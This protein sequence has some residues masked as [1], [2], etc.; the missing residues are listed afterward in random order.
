MDRW[1]VGKPDEALAK[2]IEKQCDLSPLCIKVLLSR[3][4]KDLSDIATFF[5][6]VP[7]EDPFMLKD[8]QQAVDTI[9][10]AIDSFV[11]ICVYGDYDCDGVTATAVLYNYL[12]CSGAN[13]IYYI[14]ERSEGYGMN[15]DAVRRLAE[16][17][18]KLIVTVDN[19]ISAVEEAELIEELGM[20]LVVTDHHKPPEVLPKAVAIVDPHRLDCPS[21]FKDIAGVGVALK[22][23]AALDG[24]D[25]DA[26]LEQYG[27]LVAIGTVADVV[28]LKGENRTIVNAGMRLL[29]N[30]ENQGLIELM[31]LSGMGGEKAQNMTC[32]DIAF[33]LAPRIN[34]AGRFGSP[35]SAVAL[36]LSEDEE[37]QLKAEELNDLNSSRKDCEKEIIAQIKAK[38]EKNRDLLSEKVLVIDGKGWHHGVV[39]IVASKIMEAYGKPCVLI[40]IDNNGMARGSARSMHGFNIFKCLTYCDSLLEKS[41]GHECA[42]GLSIK[43]ENIP[44][45]KQMVREYADKAETMPYTELKADKLLTREDLT[46][47]QVQSLEKLEPFGESNPEPLFAMVSAKV[48]KVIPLSQG[49]HTKLEVSYD[50]TVQDV[51]LFGRAPER[52]GIR[53]GDRVDIMVRAGIN[54]YGGTRSVSLKAEDIRLSGIKQ[55][56]AFAAMRCYDDIVCRKNVE[57]KLAALI[58]PERKELLAV[59]KAIGSG[60]SIDMLMQ[61]MYL[62]CNMNFGKT[63]ACADI[64]CE[65]GIAKL[66]DG[67]RYIETVKTEGKANL[68][69]TKTMQRFSALQTA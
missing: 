51:L 10:K 54:E 30:T 67:C 27:D 40:S 37:A 36:L 43:E 47:G 3:G 58:K 62:E 59:Y 5:E 11:P 26:V 45:F 56:K 53:Q 57:P 1:T 64:F 16:S 50:S 38:I 35:K 32:S 69:A 19:G 34:A 52:L 18:I 33:R 21:S 66:S 6:D 14:P 42:G 49:K 4:C 61:R 46:C 29:K 23:C 65:A 8:M 48:Q 12:E 39:G 28:P 15:V 60:I 31:E 24:G 9:N 68:A 13:V 2:E 17:G 55:Q 20:K 44:A 7:L 41:G 22:L 25:Y 63:R